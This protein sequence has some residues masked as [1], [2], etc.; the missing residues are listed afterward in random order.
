[1]ISRTTLLSFI[2]QTDQVATRKPPN[3]VVYLQ[4]ATCSTEPQGA[5]QCEV[6]RRIGAAGRTAV[7]VPGISNYN[8]ILNV[9]ASILRLVWASILRQS[10][11]L[12]LCRGKFLRQ[13][14]PVYN[15]NLLRIQLH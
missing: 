2:Y 5:V 9:L 3:E 1:M 11:K 15:G 6:D 14:H 8:P 13:G 10:Q 4:L 12:C 7:R